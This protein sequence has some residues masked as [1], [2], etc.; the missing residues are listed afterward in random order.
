M[1]SSKSF[2]ISDLLHLV[3]LV[4]KRI[5]KEPI[6][7]SESLNSKFTKDTISQLGLILDDDSSLG[8]MKKYYPLKLFSIRNTLHLLEEQKYNEFLYFLPFSLQI[9]SIMSPSL[10]LKSRLY[11]LS[12]SFFMFISSHP[13][14]NF[15]GHVRIMSYQYDSYE[16]FVR[17]VVDAVKNLQLCH[18]LQLEEKLKGIL[19]FQEQRST[20]QMD[21]M[22]LTIIYAKI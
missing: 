17:V 11:L 18:K 12:I 1:N 15:Y 14:K 20:I 16:N 2:Y 10:T 5:L 8:F 3:K 4:R 9:E 21:H 7:I 13:L 22:T 6:I 19:K